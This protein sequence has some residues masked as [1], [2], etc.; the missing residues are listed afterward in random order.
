[1]IIGLLTAVLVIS[2]SVVFFT[3]PPPKR[4]PDHYLQALTPAELIERANHRLRI[5]IC[6]VSVSILVGIALNTGYW[7]ISGAAMVGAFGPLI[8]LAILQRRWR[9]EGP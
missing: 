4:R 5:G 3:S 7:Q 8:T 9:Q 6:L 2:F 1:V